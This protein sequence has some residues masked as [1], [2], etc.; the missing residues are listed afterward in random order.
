MNIFLSS[1]E[2]QSS[3]HRPLIH[4]FTL[5]LTH[6]WVTADRQLVFCHWKQ[7]GFTVFPEDTSAYGLLKPGF[8]PPTLRLSVLRSLSES[9]LFSSSRSSSGFPGGQTGGDDWTPQALSAAAMVATIGCLPCLMCVCR[10]QLRPLLVP[11]IGS[12]PIRCVA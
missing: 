8:E 10:M 3:L 12:A 6:Q 7:L 1:Q 11:G 2:A 9:G 4:P 5:T